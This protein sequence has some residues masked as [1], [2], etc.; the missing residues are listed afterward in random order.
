[1]IDPHVRHPNTDT[2]RHPLPVLLSGKLLITISWMLVIAMLAGDCRGAT[3]VVVVDSSLK[4]RPVQ[5]QTFGEAGASFTDE[6]RKLAT[7]P[8]DKVVQIRVAERA[9]AGTEVAVSP[10]MIEL[11][12]GQCLPGQWIGAGED[13]QS[14]IWD[15]TRLGRLTLSLDRIAEIVWKSDTLADKAAKL[16]G[17]SDQLLLVNGD[18]LDGFIVGFQVDSVEIKPAGGGEAIKLPLERLRSA[19]F[20]NPVTA[21]KGQ[22][23]ICLADGTRLRVTKLAIADDFIKADL[24]LKAKGDGG[25]KVPAMA[26]AEAVRID[27]A[28]GAGVLV[29][30]ASLPPVIVSGGEVFGLAIPPRST[31]SDVILHAPLVV[32]YELP[33][34][35]KRFS[36]LAQCPSESADA[37]WVDFEVTA[38]VDGKPVGSWHFNVSSPQAVMNFALNG[39]EMTFEL[40]SGRNGPVLDRLRLRDAVLLAESQ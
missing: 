28:T 16:N 2:G 21:A 22:S 12:D 7:M 4:A 31:G 14:V 37:A 5:L 33:A 32:R 17:A 20:A 39:K 29:D 25:E 40:T 38:K 10:S 27:L 34:G 11:T 19:R 18:T 9:R 1:M 13:G 24:E 6:E 23:L 3:P 36:A 35:A 8:A 30:L 15:S 26:L